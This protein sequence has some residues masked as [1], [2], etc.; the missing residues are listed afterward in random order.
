M[1]FFSQ[2]LRNDKKLQIDMVRNNELT[3]RQ[4]WVHVH[5]AGGFSF[6]LSQFVSTKPIHFPPTIFYAYCYDSGGVYHTSTP[7]NLR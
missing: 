4:K 7:T 1:S 3:R 6:I 2:V 5:P